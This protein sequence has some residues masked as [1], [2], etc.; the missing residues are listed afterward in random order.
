M[1]VPY[2]PG[3]VDPEVRPVFEQLVAEF[4]AE[5][6]TEVLSVLSG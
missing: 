6:A 1:D 2:E 5:Y 3:G 4:G